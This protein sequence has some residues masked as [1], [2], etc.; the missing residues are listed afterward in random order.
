[1]AGL[2]G[3]AIVAPGGY[4]AVRSDQVQQAQQMLQ[5][6]HDDLMQQLAK[7]HAEKTA[8]SASGTTAPGSGTPAAGGGA[9]DVAGLLGGA[10]PTTQPEA[11]PTPS[12]PAGTTPPKDESGPKPVPKVGDEPAKPKTPIKVKPRDDAPES[13]VKKKAREEVKKKADKLKQQVQ[14]RIKKKADAEKKPSSF[15]ARVASDEPLALKDEPAQ[16]E[17]KK[18]EPEKPKPEDPKPDPEKTTLAR[19][20]AT[21]ERAGLPAKKADTG[22]TRKSPLVKPDA[23]GG[24]ESPA[25]PKT[26]ESRAHAETLGV[27]HDADP[28]TLK[29]AF[30]DKVK[31]WHPDVWGSASKEDQAHASE[32]FKKV[33][34][35]NDHLKKKISAAGAQ[36]AAKSADSFRSRTGDA[37]KAA[38][39]RDATVE[40]PADAEDKPSVKTPR[41][42]RRDADDEAGSKEP[43]DKSKETLASKVGVEDPKAAEAP[44][45]KAPPTEA[46]KKEHIA[47]SKARGK[48]HFPGDEGHRAHAQL[49]AH[50][51]NTSTS[52]MKRVRKEAEAAMRG[53]EATFLGKSF[54]AEKGEDAH[55][56]AVRIHDHRVNHPRTQKAR[57]KAHAN[58]AIRDAGST[59]GGKLST[60]ETSKAS[61]ASS[62][63][64][65]LHIP[66]HALLQDWI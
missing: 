59:A 6:H 11:T 66:L 62:Q 4:V 51:E 19:T 30:R 22:L 33:V 16:A 44:S 2:P 24:A 45:E 50:S 10:K 5:K 58:A 9:V 64:A 20:A 28:T 35:A 48:L 46:E 23:E 26:P 36:A 29:K 37:T 61:K 57:N 63:V 53:E 39:G 17:P 14:D 32:Q 7:H 27:A 18:D 52:T 38:T 40:K 43:E 60:A 31:R 34:A 55:D 65:S 54:K 12:T 42:T 15:A 1:M 13:D 56:I 41:I 21:A 3:G 8:S 49:K 25:K 47:K